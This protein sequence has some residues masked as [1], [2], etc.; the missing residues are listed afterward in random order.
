MLRKDGRLGRVQALEADVDYESK[1]YNPNLQ[2]PKEVKKVKKEGYPILGG[3]SEAFPRLQPAEGLT[4][5]KNR[6]ARRGTPN[7]CK[8]TRESI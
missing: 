8:M 3:A 4:E 1:G 5:Q 2:Y 6:L 7:C